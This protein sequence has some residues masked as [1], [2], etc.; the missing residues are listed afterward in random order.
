MGTY[1]ILFFVSCLLALSITPLL[2]WVA[3]SNG[4][5][6]YPIEKR[7]IHK[8]AVPRVGGI[9][10]LISYL[11]TMML[12]YVFFHPKFHKPVAYLIGLPIGAVI[13]SILGLWDDLWNLDDRK[14][15]AGQITAALVIMPYGFIIR[16][17]SIPF[18]GVVEI[19][20]QLGIPLTLFWIVGIVNTINFIDGIDGLAAGTAITIALALSIVSIVTDQLPLA[21]ICLILAG[22]TIGFLRY[23]VHPATIFMG[24]CGA[25][26]LGFMLASISIKVLFHNPA[27]TA[28][29]LVPVLIF[30]LPIVDTSWAIV[31]RARRQLSPFHADC[32][33]THHRLINLGL[34]QRQAVAILYAVSSLSIA[35]GLI[36]A[37]AG[38]EKLAIILPAFMLA[39]ALTGIIMLGRAS[40]VETPET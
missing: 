1:A 16:K 2:R 33:H 29:S 31:R 5:L 37:F 35:A 18:V 12:F 10:I 20:W 25:M 30:G 13:I 36:I 28:S 32:F 4:A 24:D 9:A 19:G 17:F 7:R 38:S 11:I 22:S 8:K 26:L 27:I 34:T 15:L 40:P 21:I 14:K 3:T 23:N 39:V 6:D